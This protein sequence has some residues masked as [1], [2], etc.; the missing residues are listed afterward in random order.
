LPGFKKK[1]RKKLFLKKI[2]DVYVDGSKRSVDKLLK[3]LKIKDLNKGKGCVSQVFGLCPG[4]G[5]AVHKCRVYPQAVSVSGCSQALAVFLP[6]FFHSHFLLH[7]A[8]R[9]S[10]PLPLD[11]VGKALICQPQ[12]PVQRCG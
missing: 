3:T 11:T 5:Q 6:R 10:P 12:C 4:W 1:S 9:P 8:C 7:G 2:E